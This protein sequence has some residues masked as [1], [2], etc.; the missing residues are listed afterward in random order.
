MWYAIRMV[1]I[2]RESPACPSTGHAAGLDYTARPARE[3]WK[4]WAAVQ[5]MRGQEEGERKS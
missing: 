5:K 4:A 2:V 3:P 1:C